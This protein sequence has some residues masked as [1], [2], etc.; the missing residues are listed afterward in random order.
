[1]LNKK[2]RSYSKCVHWLGVGRNTQHAI[3]F[4]VKQ[5]ICLHIRLS[6]VQSQLPISIFAMA[7]CFGVDGRIGRERIH[8]HIVSMYWLI[9]NIKK[10][11]ITYTKSVLYSV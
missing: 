7:V 8:S 9:L 4:I 6:I 2:Q 10:E 11:E 5:D 1:M 3:D